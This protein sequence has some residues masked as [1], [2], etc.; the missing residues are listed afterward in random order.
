[1]K[2]LVTGAA[3]FIGTHV[4]RRLCAQGREVRALLAPDEDATPLAGLDIELV[5]GDVRDLDACRRAVA[6]CARVFHLAGLYRIWSPDDRV[7][8]DVN[9]TGSANMMLA[10]GRAEVGRV[11]YTSSIAAIGQY[12]DGRPADEEAPFNLW[13]ETNAYV[14]SKYVAE[15]VVRSFARAG[16]PVVIVNPSFP[17]GEGDRGP[18]PTGQVLLDL[19]RGR[20]PGILEGG[21][22]V[23]DVEDVAE[24][25][26]LAEER[27]R[28]GERYLLANQNLTFRELAG[29]LCE[30]TGRPAP[31]RTLPFPLFWG[32]AAL[33]ELAAD[34][35]THRPPIATRKTVRYLHRRLY[36]DPTKARRELGLP[37]TDIRVTLRKAARWFESQGYLR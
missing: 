18:T 31:R 27:G 11:V 34:H 9:V 16:L 6:G 26:L 33:A 19:L 37:Q 10:S 30:V 25:H 2:T 35:V 1:M 20:T 21:V 14:R 29:L 3:G 15:E 5:R 32:I 28:L 13:R 22:N 12:P 17:L 8:F 23:V 36:F 7:L 4:V 24:G